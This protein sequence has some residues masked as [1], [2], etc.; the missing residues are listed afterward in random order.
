M[1]EIFLL[2]P[3]ASTQ[4]HKIIAVSSND[5]DH[6]IIP[7]AKGVYCFFGLNNSKSVFRE[8]VDKMRLHFGDILDFYL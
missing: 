8:N 1:L 4:L 5:P 7:S 2:H 6:A 3:A